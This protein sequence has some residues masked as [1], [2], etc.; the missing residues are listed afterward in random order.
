MKNPN[1]YLQVEGCP[2]C[3]IW[4]KQKLPKRI[5]YFSDKFMIGQWDGNKEPVVVFREH[6]TEISK[7]SWGRILQKCREMFGYGMRLLIMKGR[8]MPKDHWHAVIRTGRSY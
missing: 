8:N 5:Y 1:D 7:E 4:T 2:F 6:I 3:E